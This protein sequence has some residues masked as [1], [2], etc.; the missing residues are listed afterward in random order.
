[1]ATG[2]MAPAPK[3][4]DENTWP[5]IILKVQRHARTGYALAIT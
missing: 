2:I 3:K 4:I 5:S 1:M